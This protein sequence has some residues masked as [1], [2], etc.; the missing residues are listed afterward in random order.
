M[1]SG[2]LPGTLRELIATELAPRVGLEVVE[3]VV[4][5]G[6]LQVADEVFLTNALMGIVSLTEVDALPIGTGIL[7]PVSLRL[8]AELEIRERL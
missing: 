2:A 3:R 6:D 7:G 8:R 5:P 1:T 4:R